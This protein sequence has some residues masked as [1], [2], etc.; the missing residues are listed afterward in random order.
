MNAGLQAFYARWA[1]QEGGWPAGLSDLRAATVGS[2][3]M[4]GGPKRFYSTA[5]TRPATQAK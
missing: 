2:G 1:A 5:L 3:G 4:W